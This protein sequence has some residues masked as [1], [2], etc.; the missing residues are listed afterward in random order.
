MA[1]IIYLAFH[2]I[3]QINIQAA[4]WQPLMAYHICL[5]SQL[6]PSGILIPIWLHRR[7]SPSNIII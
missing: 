4:L 3:I 2:G 6:C 5:A 7:T 1:C